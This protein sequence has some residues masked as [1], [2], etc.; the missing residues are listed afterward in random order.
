MVRQLSFFAVQLL[1]GVSLDDFR[2]FFIVLAD[3]TQCK[4]MGEMIIWRRMEM[5]C[6]P[7]DREMVVVCFGEWFA[8][9][10]VLVMNHWR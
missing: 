9:I 2:I 4:Q 3:E 6:S 1:R 8:R 5:G 10:E 7:C